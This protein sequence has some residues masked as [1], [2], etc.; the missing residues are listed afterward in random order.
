LGDLGVD[1]SII[2][3]LIFE[4]YG[5]KVGTGFSWLR[6]GLN[7]GLCEHSDDPSSSIK[8]RLFI[9]PLSNYQ[10]FCKSLHSVVS[11]QRGDKYEMQL[12]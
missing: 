9:D 3:K 5:V 12:R 2:S 6:I 7:N 8:S 10:I 11:L 1:G 4:K